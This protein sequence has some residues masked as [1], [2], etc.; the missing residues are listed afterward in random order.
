MLEF[1]SEQRQI[2]ENQERARLSQLSEKQLMI[3]MILLLERIDR[4]IFMTS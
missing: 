3:E 4:S 2:R 1:L